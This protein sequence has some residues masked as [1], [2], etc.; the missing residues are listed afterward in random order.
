MRGLGRRAGTTISRSSRPSDPYSLR[1]QPLS[2]SKKAN[3][4]CE[5]SCTC[6]KV[7]IGEIKRLLETR[8]KEHKEASSRDKTDKSAVAEHAH[9]GRKSIPINW[10]DTKI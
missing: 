9:L 4:V 1:S 6:G 7:Y 3:I 8:L 10:D 2:Q 5:M